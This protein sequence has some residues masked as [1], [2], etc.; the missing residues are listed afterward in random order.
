MAYG[1]LGE[2][3]DAAVAGVPVWLRP[4]PFSLAVSAA[5]ALA[6]LPVAF[7]EDYALERRSGL[8]DRSR[9]AWLSDYVKGAA[10]SVGLTA[11]V[12][13]LLGWAIRR[14][15]NAWPWL[16]SAGTLPLFVVGNLVVPLYVMPLFNAF[17]PVTG[18]LERRLRALGEPLGVGDAEI[19]RM[20]MSRQTR[21]AN[22]FVT[23]IGTT[24]RIVLGDTLIDAFPEDE[25]AFVVAHEIGH[26][27]SRDTWRLIAA[28][29]ALA[30]GLFLIARMATPKR[31]RE[32]LRDRPLLIARSYATMLVATQALRPVL[33]AFSR[34]REWAADRFATGVTRDP[35]TGASALRRLRDQ[36]LADDDPPLWYELLFGSHPSL[37]ARIEALERS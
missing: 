27:V 32:L 12:A 24:H 13:T 16:A 22:A 35:Q 33:L 37:K 2:S 15:P 10:I 29:E 28:G 3:L 17:E 4:L 31:V 34:S 21:K 23:G 6:D 14:A 20:D 1:P 26:Y 36:N 30:A 9:E 25:V 5:S 19:L 7:V 11:F 18:S 8:S